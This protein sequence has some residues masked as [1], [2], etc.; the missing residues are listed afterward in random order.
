[1]TIGVLT[2]VTGGGYFGNILS[3]IVR[4]AAAAGGRVLA[5]QT[6]DPERHIGIEVVKSRGVV[7]G[8]SSRDPLLIRR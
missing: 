2:P 5:L 6:L 4:A 8:V 1:V 7:Y 3:G